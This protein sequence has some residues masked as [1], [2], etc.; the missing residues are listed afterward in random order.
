MWIPLFD[1]RVGV[2]AFDRVQSCFVLSGAQEQDMRPPFKWDASKQIGVANLPQINL[3]MAQSAPRMWVPLDIIAGNGLSFGND[4]GEIASSKIKEIKNEHHDDIETEYSNPG[5]DGGLGDGN[6]HEDGANNREQ[7]VGR[8]SEDVPGAGQGIHAGERDGYGDG[9]DPHQD[10]AGRDRVT[11]EAANS[12]AV[13]VTPEQADTPVLSINHDNQPLSLHDNQ[14]VAAQEH[15]NAATEAVPVEVAAVND[16]SES[17]DK[18]KNKSSGKAKSGFFV[19]GLTPDT[20]GESRSIK[21]KARDNIAAIALLGSLPEGAMID[22]DQASVLLKYCGWG[23]MPAA[24]FKTDGTTAKGWEDIA[25]S[26]RNLLSD[27]DYDAAMRSTMDA[28]YTAVDV[29]NAMWR[30]VEK[31]GLKGGAILEPSCGTGLFFGAMPDGMRKKSVHYGI[32]LDTTTARITALLYPDVSVIQKGFQDVAG[33][34]N[35]FDLAIG[36]P[37]FGSQRLYDVNRPDLSDAS[38][39]IHDYFFLKSMSALKP[40][41]IMPMVVSRYLL[42]ASSAEHVK[43]RETLCREAELLGAVR[44]PETAFKKNA[45]TDV[46]TDIL[47]FQKRAEPL[48]VDADLSGVDWIY[49]TDSIAETDDG[50]AIPGNLYYA[51]HPERILGTP[52]LVRGM[53]KENEVSVLDTRDNWLVD[54]NRFMDEMPSVNL[55]SSKKTAKKKT[56]PELDAAAGRVPVGSY[57]NHHGKIYR[58]EQDVI[59]KPGCSLAD[60]EELPG[61]GADKLERMAGI[62]AMR[63]TLQALV[64]HQMQDTSDAISDDL[65]KRLRGQYE[66]FVQKHSFLHSSNNEQLMRDDPT[67]PQ[68]VSLEKDYD[69]GISKAVAKRTGEKSKAPSAKNADILVRRTQYPYIIPTS[70]DNPMDALRLSMREKNRVD[71]T[72]I[73]SLLKMSEESATESI[74]EHILVDPKTMKWMLRDEVLSGHVGIKLDLCN[75]LLDGGDMSD[76]NLLEIGRTLSALSAAQPNPIP[77]SDIAVGP[78]APWIPSS[79]VKDFLTDINGVYRVSATYIDGI[80]S[81][82]LSAETS[83]DKQSEWGTAR[84]KTIEVVNAMFNQR[85]L[86]VRNPGLTPGTYVIDKEQTALALARLEKM[87]SYWDTWVSVSADRADL[88]TKIYNDKFNRTVNRVY[89]GSYLDLPGSSNTIKVRPQQKNVVARSLSTNRSLLC[90]HAVGTGKT[91]AAVAMAMEARRLGVARKPMIVVPNHL[92]EQWRDAFMQLYPSAHILAANSRDMEAGNRQRFLGNIAC[93]DYDAV[94]IGHSSFAMIPPA[95]EMVKIFLDEEL[96]SI[97]ESIAK[98]DALQK[99]DGKS[100]NRRIKDMQRAK[101]RLESKIK[102]AMDSGR[103]DKGINLGQI[104]VDRL[105]VDESHSFK[106]TPFVT[107][108]RGVSGLGNPAGSKRAEDMLIKVRSIQQANE[109]GGVVFLTATPISNSLAEMHGLTRFL[110]NDALKFHGLSHFD[111]WARTFANIT[112]AYA[113]TLTG[114]FKEKTSLATFN[115]MPELQ[116]M[117]QQFADIATRKDVERMLLAAGMPPVK[118]P[119]LRGGM[120]EIVVCQLTDIQRAIIGKEI[121]KREDGSAIYSE[122]SILHRLD[123]LPKNPGPGDD[124]ILVI[125]SDLRKV[126]LDAKVFFPDIPASGGKIPAC[127]ENVWNEYELFKDD[128]GTQLVFLDYSTPKSDKV[129]A[130]VKVTIQ[131]TIEVEEGERDDATDAAIHK[132]DVARDHLEKMSPSEIEDALSYADGG[133]WSAYQEIRGELIKKGIGPEEIAFIHDW[134]SPEKREDLFGRVRSGRIRVL[135]GSTSKMGPGMNVQN[136]MTAL[137]NLDAPWKPSDLEQRNGRLIRQGNELLEKYGD[138]FKVRLCYYVT[139]DSGEAGMYDVLERK[140]KFTEQL[141]SGDKARTAEDPEAAAMDPGRIKALAS[142]NAILMD[143]VILSDKVRRMELLRR[144]A[145]EEMR[146]QERIRQHAVNTIEILE[147]GMA[148]RAKSFHLAVATLGLI[149][150]S[151]LDVEKLAREKKERRVEERRALAE[152]RRA[153]KEKEKEAKKEAKKKAK[154][155]DGK[156]IVEE[157]PVDETVDETVDD[158][159]DDA[160]NETALDVDNMESNAASHNGYI[161]FTPFMRG[162]AVPQSHKLTTA[163]LGE[164]MAGAY[165]DHMSRNGFIPDDGLLLG[166]ING[167]RVLF[168]KHNDYFGTNT[169]LRIETENGNSVDGMVFSFGSSSLTTTGNRTL[170]LVRKMVEELD[171][172]ETNTEIK[173]LRELVASNSNSPLE[174]DGA[175]TDLRSRLAAAT[176]ALRSGFKKWQAF[177]NE[178]ERRARGE[179]PPHDNTISEDA[180]VARQNAAMANMD[181]FVEALEP[182]HKM[183]SEQEGSNSQVEVQDNG[184]DLM[185]A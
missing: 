57:F 85:P 60:P 56:D 41:G 52:D 6:R 182:A 97:Q 145:M 21:Q 30:G 39:N 136:R 127:V 148:G 45:G 157:A 38:P 120:P 180:N 122:G 2:L 89:D 106:N 133:N 11:E 149:D 93:N 91:F 140:A 4:D 170:N 59:D 46:V 146:E 40:L 32:E 74:Y 132:A 26:V 24:F 98:L 78:G 115:N 53:Y 119:E 62:L 72:Y 77:F 185:V 139:E 15:Q 116:V 84:V 49:T 153:E 123:N 14:P 90:D 10:E 111:S 69:K 83:L 184:V 183:L 22:A 95:P 80:G 82:D 161:P 112:T 105:I 70:A 92:V 158:A 162:V 7:P 54:L 124:I 181:A 143:H 71:I 31:L 135:M 129:P 28:H 1:V 5:S 17:V 173:R 51:N 178:A 172:I 13:E 141:R 43:F 166:E 67:W 34:E 113:F 154:Q 68:V 88:L 171:P 50:R 66:E 169:S 164:Q 121:D 47:F 18:P 64:H 75:V 12:A 177:V 147:N 20:V 36:N 117:Y 3:F 73:A 138:E 35:T 128:R 16:S 168:M 108:L 137:H 155:E 99:D 152:Q 81:W 37:P 48:P 110:D 33:I 27:T 63:D 100:R 150:Q 76:R 23:G 42:D 125:I 79:V 107:S 176:F 9:R 131:R 65:R 19:S 174:D 25:S 104:G 102:R 109:G 96:E 163:Q 167:L 159:D 114:G 179:T 144:G 94:I 118:I 55:P 134:D 142:G 103:K 86:V 130:W 126:A 44:L 151:R 61:R 58:R 156:T 165:S 160:V 175:L 8:G 29:I 87:R 101:V